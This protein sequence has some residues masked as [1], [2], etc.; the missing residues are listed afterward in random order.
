MWRGIVVV[1]VATGLLAVGVGIGRSVAGPRSADVDAPRTAVTSAAVELAGRGIEPAEPSTES[2]AGES[3][4]PL[5]SEALVRLPVLRPLA[6]GDD[7]DLVDA[8]LREGDV[9]A[10]GAGGEVATYE[11]SSG[12][13]WSEVHAVLSD[14]VIAPESP[15]GG[16]TGTPPVDPQPADDG[17]S[18]A[19][20]VPSSAP[21]RVV[22]R[23][24]GPEPAEDE[25]RVPEG[26]PDGVGATVRARSLPVRWNDEAVR[27]WISPGHRPDD[28]RDSPVVGCPTTR[29]A[30]PA[31]RDPVRLVTTGPI[32]DATVRW[33]PRGSAEPWSSLELDPAMLA[34]QA[35]TFDARL[36]AGVWPAGVVPLVLHCF[37]IDRELDRAYEVYAT[38]TDV[39][40]RPFVTSVTTLADLTPSGRPPTVA[41]IDARSNEATVTAWTTS[42]G[43]VQFHWFPLA[44]GEAAPPGD[45]VGR[46]AF[47][48]VARAGRA[49]EPPGVWDPAFSEGHSAVFGLPPGGGAV[50]CVSVFDSDNLLRPVGVDVL[51][52]RSPKR[53]VATVELV[54]IRLDDGVRIPRSW[55]T[56]TAGAAL[57]SGG[58]D[59]CASWWSNGDSELVAPGSRLDGTVLWHCSSSWPV[60][61]DDGAVTVPITVSR[62]IDPS[63]DRDAVRTTAALTL[64]GDDCAVGPCLP[65]AAELYAVP[66]HSGALGLRGCTFDCTDRSWAAGAV[67]IKVAWAVEGDGSTGSSLLR[68]STDRSADPVGGLP[69]IEVAERS[70]FDPAA[71]QQFTELQAEYR[72]FADRPIEVLGGS[73]VPVF[74]DAG[75]CEGERSI[76]VLTPGRT[77]EPRIGVTVPCPAQEYS[78]VLRVR[79]AAGAE[80]GL[81]AISDVSPAL[82]GRSV[83]TTVEFLRDTTGR[84]A[85]YLGRFEAGVRAGGVGGSVHRGPRVAWT[86]R[87][88]SDPNCVWFGH[89]VARDGPVDVRL[90]RPG[91]LVVAV[92]LELT[93]V[94]DGTLSGRG[95][96]GEVRVEGSFPLESLRAGTPLVLASPADARLQL[97]VTVDAVSWELDQ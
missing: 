22:D 72:L 92:D 62:R 60:T 38:G 37:E 29:S 33:R 71:G 68:S 56:V 76:R 15:D 65:R 4:P 26:C 77:T 54:G 18:G 93:T 67:I 9:D 5:G 79:D 21:A 73:V 12:L 16:S 6:V 1:A 39:R 14:S 35:A 78:V 49:V 74:A 55:L 30:G 80:H 3:G 44:P 36:S 89:T 25:A 17:S 48:F 11:P 69:R 32:A 95:A 31:G 59:S 52:L 87:Y 97:R 96:I 61:D 91:P 51:E 63:P 70:Q 86:D 40:D 58:R 13:G 28:G 24:A 20:S 34:T 19:S 50:V 66:I 84:E 81:V 43:S 85:A 41:E 82:V 75:E 94:C 8:L 88:P 83:T 47:P 64:R 45:C 2:G 90:Y 53:Q 27:A 57:G 7:P 23:C 46:R 42:A 10:S